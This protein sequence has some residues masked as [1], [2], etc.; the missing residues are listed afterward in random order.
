MAEPTG[1]HDPRCLIW[2]SDDP[3]D[4]CNCRDRHGHTARGLPDPIT[5]RQQLED[6]WRS[7][8]LAERCRR[9]DTLSAS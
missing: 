6:E 8:T 2:A 3:A 4:D 5:R 9:L 1:K 7:L